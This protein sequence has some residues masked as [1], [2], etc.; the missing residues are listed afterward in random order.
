MKR[1]LAVMAIIVLAGTLSVSAEEKELDA[2]PSGSGTLPEA[3]GG[4]DGFGYTWAD[5]AEPTCAYQF[6]DIAATGTDLGDGDDV[7]F[8]VTLGIGGFDF[9]GTT[10]TD[11]YMGSNGFL[12]TDNNGGDLSNDC[13]LPA[14]PSTGAGARMYVMH[15]DLDVDAECADCAAYWQYFAD[16]PRPNDEGLAPSGCDILQWNAQHYPGG[17]GNATEIFQLIV[18]E[19]REIVMQVS[20]CTECGSSST[21]GIQN[22]A[23][24]IGLTY[25]CETAASLAA[26]TAVCF[27]HPDP[28]PVNLKSFNVD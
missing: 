16:C 20:A 3:T 21:T 19:T 1:V 9:Y 23:A 27:F 17:T 7:A 22:E 13:P 4:P 5:Q 26:G 2:T 12:T 14:T 28:V 6:V 18:Y 15:D 11:V 8:P 24:S 10:Y 25:A